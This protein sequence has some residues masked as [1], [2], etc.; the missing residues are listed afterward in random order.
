MLGGSMAGIRPVKPVHVQL[1]E[2]LP[3]DPDL[4]TI[5]QWWDELDDIATLMGTHDGF[6][7]AIGNSLTKHTNLPA[8][9]KYGW[10]AYD[11]AGSLVGFIS[12]QTDGTEMG[13]VYLVDPCRRGFGIGQAILRE[14]IRHDT[15]SSIGTFCCTIYPR[16]KASAAVVEKVGFVKDRQIENYFTY[17]RRPP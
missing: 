4:D 12:G 17:S 14:L 3:S 10:G 13:F 11:S 1:R 7:S 15:C 6:K 2:L 9:G 16:N 8:R 5:A